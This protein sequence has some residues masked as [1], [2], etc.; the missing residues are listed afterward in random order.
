MIQPA[1]SS[2]RL[3]LLAGLTE[4]LTPE[5]ARRIVEYKFDA[6]SQAKLAD[7]AHRSN[8]GTLSAGE[9]DEYLYYVEVIDFIGVLKAKA[10]KLL[11]STSR[12]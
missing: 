3:D 6:G 12:I 9:R 8:E 4:C 1:P 11:A 7:L 10:R 2:P 5:A